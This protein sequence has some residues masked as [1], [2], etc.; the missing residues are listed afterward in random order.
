VPHLTETNHRGVLGEAAGKSKRAIEELVARL[1]PQPPVPTVI[2]KLP[3]SGS[4]QPA[5]A[6]PLAASPVAPRR[7][8][9]PAVIAPLSEETFKVQFTASRAF[10]DKLRQAQDLLRHRLPSGDIAEILERAV[11]L[12]IEKVRKERFA[13]TRRP[14]KDSAA[15]DG[16]VSSRYVPAST[17][18]HVDSRDEGRCAFV[19]ARGKR[20]EERGMIEFDHIDGFA[21]TR[22]HDKDR[23]RLLCRVHNQLLAEKRYGRDFMERAKAMRRRT[24]RSGTGRDASASNPLPRADQISMLFDDPSLVAGSAPR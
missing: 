3:Q 13:A 12:L 8:D 2:R 4:E 23:M 21:E 7:I 9:R 1:A 14:K 24:T 11:D 19:D 6:M 10:R 16:P 22:S 18:C 5:L 17:R 20:C 15:T